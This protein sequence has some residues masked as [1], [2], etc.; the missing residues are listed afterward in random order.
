PPKQLG[1]AL[2][3]QRTRS[4]AKWPTWYPSPYS[5]TPPQRV[6]G[7]TA[8]FSFVGHASWL[9]QTGGLNILIDSVWSERA[10]PFKFA[11]PKRVND[12]GI[13]FGALPPIDVVLVSHGHY[14]HLDVVTLS[15]L[16]AAHSPRVITPLGND[17]AMRA[18]NRAIR[19]EPFDWGDRVDLGNG[20]AV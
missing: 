11:G 9:I 10:S 2:R 3:W 7:N 14:D 20:I 18:R 8:R 15:R 12:P 13:A 17:L 5:D 19:A 4:P 16:A 6:N 1:D